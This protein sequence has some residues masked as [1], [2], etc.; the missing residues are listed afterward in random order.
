MLFKV[1]TARCKMAATIL[2]TNLTYKHRQEIHNN[3]AILIVALLDQL[4]HHVETIKIDGRSYRTK[5]QVT[6]TPPLSQPS[7]APPSDQP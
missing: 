1:L 2:A 4:L 6:P 7:P 5:L 3:D